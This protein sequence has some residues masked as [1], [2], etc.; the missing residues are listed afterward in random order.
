MYVCRKIRICNYL[1]SKG[2]KPHHTEPSIKDP[3]RIVWMFENH[4]KLSAAVEEYYNSKDFRMHNPGIK[5]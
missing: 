1:M 3:G 5:T 4:P 2:F